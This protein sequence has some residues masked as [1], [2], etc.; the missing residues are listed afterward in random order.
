[1]RVLLLSHENDIDGVNCVVLAKLAFEELDYKLFPSVSVL[2]KNFRRML[3]DGTL[4]SYDRIFITDLALENPSLDMLAESPHCNKISIL[5]HH[6]SSIKSGL[7]CYDFTKIEEKR[8]DGKGRCGTALFYDHLTKNGFL[9]QSPILDEFVELTRLED[10]W[11]WKSSGT[12]GSFAHDIAILFSSMSIEDYLDHMLASIT[13]HE[14]FV[15]TAEE[16]SLISAKKKEFEDKLQKLWDETEILEDEFGNTYG[17]VLADYE[18]RNELTEYIRKLDDQ[19]GI[20]YII[21]IDMEK[22]EFGQKSYRSIVEGF[23][24]NSIASSHGG[25]GHKEAAGVNI[26]EEQKR[27]SLTLQRR[28]KI[29]YLCSCHFTK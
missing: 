24:V 21:I 9:P 29:N 7:N 17:A 22:G 14:K 1:M 8:P 2:E 15:F 23:D 12:I 13:T 5:D 10:T 28:D 20:S 25:G 6:I 19:K 26:M 4:E 16:Q 11:E 27:M 18:Y 3:Q